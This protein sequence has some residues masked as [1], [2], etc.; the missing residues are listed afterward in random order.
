M[1][2]IMK[3][4]SIQNL[5][6][7]IE[8]LESDAISVGIK[9]GSRLRIIATLIERTESVIDGLK[10]QVDVKTTRRAGGLDE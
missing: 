5:K 9:K 1:Y 7:V 3:F 4:A 2:E 10:E 6:E 8:L